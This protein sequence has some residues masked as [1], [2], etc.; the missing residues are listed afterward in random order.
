MTEFDI[1]TDPIGRQI[2][3]S[4]KGCSGEVVVPYGVSIIEDEAFGYQNGMTA[5]YIPD[6]VREIGA[7]AFKQCFSL[8]S[9]RLPKRLW[10]IEESLFR[11]CM[12]LREIR[13]P[14]SVREIERRA[15]IGCTRLENV[16]AEPGVTSIGAESFSMCKALKTVTLPDTVESVS[17]LCFPSCHR[18]E[19]IYTR[20]L[21]FTCAEDMMF[22]S[23][24]IKNV[25]SVVGAR[26]FAYK[27][28]TQEERDN[29]DLL[30]KNRKDDFIEF[31]IDMKK[32]EAAFLAFENKLITEKEYNGIKGKI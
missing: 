6:T 29:I 31:A 2:L 20:L 24:G 5:L 4:V 22:I 17:V 11:E 27:E 18:L 14:G 26:L 15:F 19:R 21:D 16:Y 8:T 13:I 7:Y 3:Y 25:F 23:E 30:L 32:E 12:M 28:M 9:V 10:K 1:K